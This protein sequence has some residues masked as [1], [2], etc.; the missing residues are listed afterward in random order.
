M[1]AL[2]EVVMAVVGDVHSDLS[3]VKIV[4]TTE[5]GD[6][7]IVGNAGCQQQSIGQQNVLIHL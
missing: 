4:R 1:E 3:N 6:A 5:C 2:L 7:H